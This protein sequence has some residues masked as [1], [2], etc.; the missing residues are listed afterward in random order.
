M[1]KPFDLSQEE[2][3]TILRLHL[4]EKRNFGTR[5]NEQTENSGLKP[6]NPK[7]VLNTFT[8][9]GKTSKIIFNSNGTYQ[10]NVPLIN[11]TKSL[12]GSW[13]F[14]QK[15]GTGGSIYYSSGGVTDGFIQE[16]GY[17]LEMNDGLRN[18]MYDK[19]NDYHKL[20]IMTK[21]LNLKNSQIPSLESN[22]EITPLIS[23]NKQ[24]GCPTG[25]VRDPN[26]Y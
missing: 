7:E 14:V 4:G 21:L 9:D 24:L 16:L 15:S 23:K 11:N 22:K 1:K 18:L 3:I 8:N 17:D 10:S 12:Q 25:C 5:L 26:F 19:P 20:P 6:G 13:K 2:K